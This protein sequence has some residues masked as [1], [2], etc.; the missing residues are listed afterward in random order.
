MGFIR[1]KNDWDDCDALGLGV[2]VGEFPVNLFLQLQYPPR[3]RAHHQLRTRQD[4]N[5]N[6]SNHR[7]AS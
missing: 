4:L 3:E 7:V 6:E 2:I 1:R 5:K